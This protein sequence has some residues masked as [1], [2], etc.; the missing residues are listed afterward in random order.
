MSRLIGTFRADQK[1]ERLFIKR[2]TYSHLVAVFDVAFVMVEASPVRDA[3]AALTHLPVPL[4]HHAQLARRL[5]R[6]GPRYGP[7]EATVSAIEEPT[8]ESLAAAFPGHV[9]ALDDEQIERAVLR[10]V[11]PELRLKYRSREYGGEQQLWFKLPAMK[12]VEDVGHIMSAV[13]GARFTRASTA[14][15]ILDAAL[16]LLPG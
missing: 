9:R 5:L 4:P 7:V 2:D 16:G 14:D 1:R 13:Y 11:P 10:R 8:P 12:G 3:A 6:F 15:G